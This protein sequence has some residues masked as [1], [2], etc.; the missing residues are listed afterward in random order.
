MQTTGS[1][2]IEVSHALN[3]TSLGLT[4]DQERVYR[5]LLRSPGEVPADLSGV[6]VRAVLDQLR[7]LEVVDDLHH[8]APPAVVVDRLIRRRVEQTSREL[9]RLSSAWVMVRDLV[10]EQLRGRPVELVE[11]IEGG[12]SVNR[13]VWHLASTATETMNMKT[14]PRSRAEP[15]EKAEQA[16]HRRLATGL[17]SR[18]LVPAASLDDPTQRAYA[19]RQHAAGDHHRVSDHH[20]RQLLIIDRSVAFV[21][22]DPA[23]Q[24]AGAVEIRQPGIVA[25]LVESFEAAWTRAREL[26]VPLTTIERQVLRSLAQYDKDE[27]AARALN[28]S[29]RKYRAHVADVMTRLGA[30]TRFQ[31]GLLAKDRGW[32]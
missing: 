6:D 16:F 23:D 7:D 3:L 19:L 28:I 4:V 30:T 5:H 11:R 21:Q 31:A 12:D 27:A 25:T 20:T 26:D 32:L 15:D 17:T 14:R 1:G 10:E 9:H 8:P 18:T 13:R 22:L 29:L 2:L 24:W